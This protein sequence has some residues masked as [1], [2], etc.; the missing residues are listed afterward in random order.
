[1]VLI[2]GIRAHLNTKKA[3][4]KL[5]CFHWSGIKTRSL[6]ATPELHDW[7]TSC[8]RKL[9]LQTATG[10]FHLLPLLGRRPSHFKPF[11][12]PPEWRLFEWSGIKDSNLRPR[13]PKP[14]ALANCANPRK[15]N[16]LV[17]RRH[18]RSVA[19]INRG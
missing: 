10:S 3:E 18:K 7:Q 4:Q 13:G 17:F 19:R 16:V 1:V 12:K 11:K 5:N 9:L 14:R 8:Q 2:I 6:S 15:T